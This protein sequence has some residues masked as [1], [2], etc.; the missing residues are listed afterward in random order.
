MIQH[1]THD[2]R[3][4]RHAASLSANVCQRTVVI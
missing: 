4:F 1:E 2:T 3:V